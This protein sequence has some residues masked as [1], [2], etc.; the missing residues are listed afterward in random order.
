MTFNRE[1]FR[2]TLTEQRVQEKMTEIAERIVRTDRDA[3]MDVFA[4]M[5][6]E[7]F[8]N[9]VANNPE[10][11]RIALSNIRLWGVVRDDAEQQVSIDEMTMDIVEM[12]TDIDAAE[13]AEEER[14]FREQEQREADEAAHAT[15][16]GGIDK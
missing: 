5:D 3:V 13:D 14:W 9:I 16:Y 2:E 10:L 8:L 1:A 12:S 15:A 11:Y 6:D 4:S 7:T